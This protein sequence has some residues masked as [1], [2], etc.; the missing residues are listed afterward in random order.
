M[1]FHLVHMSAISLGT[2]LTYCIRSFL[3]VTGITEKDR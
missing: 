2:N 3:L 1:G